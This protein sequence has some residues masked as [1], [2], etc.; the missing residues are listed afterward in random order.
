MNHNVYTLGRSL[1]LFKP[2][3]SV[4]SFLTTF[5]SDYVPLSVPFA[6]ILNKRFKTL[7]FLLLLFVMFGSIFCQLAFLLLEFTV[8]SL[9]FCRGEIFD[10]KCR[11][12][13]AVKKEAVM[14]DDHERG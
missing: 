6:L 14:L 11:G 1:R 3:H 12:R 7:Y 5:G 4:D 2:D 10:F 13:N 8:S 9:I